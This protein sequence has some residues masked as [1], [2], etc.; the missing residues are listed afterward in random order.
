MRVERTLCCIHCIPQEVPWALTA[1]KRVGAQVIEVPQESKCE[2]CFLISCGFPQKS[3]TKLC[4]AMGTQTILGKQLKEAHASAEKTG[5]TG[6][7][8]RQR[9]RKHEPEFGAVRAR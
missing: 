7:A 8:W 3:W 9:H 1:R 5:G 4:A 6:E 2:K